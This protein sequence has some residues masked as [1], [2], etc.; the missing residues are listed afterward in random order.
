MISNSLLVKICPRSL[1]L[2]DNRALH[3][4]QRAGLLKNELK[5]ISLLMFKKIDFFFLCRS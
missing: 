1:V 5:Q 3:G 4:K 2:S